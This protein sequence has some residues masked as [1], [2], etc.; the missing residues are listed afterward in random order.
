MNGE[1]DSFMMN[2]M[3]HAEQ[4][5]PKNATAI[6]IFVK[7]P[8]SFIENVDV[9]LLQV[10]S[11]IGNAQM[12]THIEESDDVRISLIAA[13]CTAYDDRMYQMR[14]RYDD[15]IAS[16]NTDTVNASDVMVGMDN[17]F[18]TRLTKK[19]LTEDVDTSAL[20]L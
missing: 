20:N 7:G 4:P 19:V 14:Q 17:P 11:E 9:S 3:N 10:R 16:A 15:I 2:L 8:K 12:Y 6:G 5:M 13:G 18:A 1:E